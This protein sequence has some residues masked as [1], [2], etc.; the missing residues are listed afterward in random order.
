MSPGIQPTV[1]YTCWGNSS[2]LTCDKTKRNFGILKH[3]SNFYVICCVVC[4]SQSVAGTWLQ[5]GFKN[6]KIYL[7]AVCTFSSYCI[8][9]E[10]KDS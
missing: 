7:I 8:Y 3:G 4:L 2:T 6:T 10:K 9:C 5:E 1:I